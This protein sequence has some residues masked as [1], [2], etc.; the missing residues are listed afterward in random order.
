MLRDICP[1]CP[2][3]S[4]SGGRGTRTHKSFR[5][6]IFKT[7]RLPVSV[8]LRNTAYRRLSDPSC[9]DGVRRER[10]PSPPHLGVWSPHAGTAYV[11]NGS[12]ARSQHV[13]A[14]VGPQRLRDAHAAVGLLVILQQRHDGSPHCAG[15][16]VESVDQPRPLRAP[17]ADLQP[18]GLVVGR[19]RGRGHLH[20]TVGT[21]QPRLVVDLLGGRGAEVAGA[22][23]KHSI[24]DLEALQEA[25]LVGP[26]GL[27]L[28]PRVVGVGKR[29]LLY[30]VKLVHPN[31]ALGFLPVGPRLPAKAR[32]EAR[33]AKRQI[34]LGKDLVLVH[35]GHCNLGGPDEIEVIALYPVVLE[36][37]CGQKT[38]PVHRPLPH[39]HRRYHRLES[40]LLEKSMAKRTSANSRMTPGPV[41]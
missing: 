10:L 12:L 40:A 4:Q 22:H 17:K 19:V 28:I 29:E 38:G 14:R 26:D 6:T 9:R 15:R 27:Q 23:H 34:V 36:L 3:T 30:L 2:A 35:G 32:R 21:R 18:A 31:K 41:R 39:H 25:L 13:E 11:E 8:A 1:G 20:V 5:T 33:V 37:I 7:V 16:P 24:R